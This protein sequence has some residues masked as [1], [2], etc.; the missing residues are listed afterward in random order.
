[1]SVARYKGL[2]V[3]DPPPLQDVKNVN[4]DLHA[5]SARLV[6]I[7]AVLIPTLSKPDIVS[8]QRL[9]ACTRDIIK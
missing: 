5:L 6:E 4:Q 2:E 7:S 1:M 8:N 9:V 3:V